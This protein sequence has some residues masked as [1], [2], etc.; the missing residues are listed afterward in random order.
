MRRRFALFLSAML[1]IFSGVANANE[2]IREAAEAF[3]SYGF[4][5]G[6]RLAPDGQRASF[7]TQHGSDVPVATVID[8]GGGGAQVVLASDAKKG[9]DIQWCGWKNDTRLLCGFYGL[10]RI[11]HRLIPHTRLVAVSADGSNTQVLAQRQQSEEF[12]NNQDEIVDWLPKD[13]SSILLQ[14]RKGGGTGVSSADIYK[15]KLT[16]V[17]RPRDGV[18]DWMSN[19][20]GE[21][22]IRQHVSETGAETWRYRPSEEEPWK[23]LHKMKPGGEG[24]EFLPLGFGEDPTKLLVL[25]AQEGRDALWS[26]DLQNELE[27]EVVYAHPKADITG[28][29]RLGRNRR[30]V[31]ATYSTDIPRAKYFDPRVDE[32]MSKVS[33]KISDGVIHIVDESWDRRFYLVFVE[34]D[35]NARTYY[36]F[37]SRSGSL[38]KIV[39]AF[40]KLKGRTLGEVKIIEY[41]SDDGVLV[42]GYLTLPAGGHSG[43]VPTIL[44]PHGGP[45]ARDDWGFDFL[46]QFLASQGYAVLQS[47]Y[48]GSSGYGKAWEGEGAYKG[49][50]RATTDLEYGLRYLVSEGIADADRICSVGWSYGGYAALMSAIEYP[51]RHRCVV[52]IA[53]VADLNQ[54]ISDARKSAR[55]FVGNSSKLVRNMIGQDPAV[56][57]QG[58]PL[59]RADELNVPVL[60]FHGDY[61]I[62]VPIA[63][64][65][66]MNKAL[67]KKD[68][69]YIEYE[70]DDHS[71]RKEKH[72]IDLLS[73]L[74]EFL[75]TNL[76]P[77]E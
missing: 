65:K 52:S 22:L 63:H 7:L 11:R 77:R 41:P 62:N 54:L 9:I 26:I 12:S 60:L 64:S 5:R 4:V 33:K 72:R 17:E 70:D 75:K 20:R 10:A 43:P 49:W 46:A 40:P 27:R 37:D 15:N 55:I 59:K 53:G 69:K 38:D 14:V 48:R 58:S 45:S 29:V 50:K 42:P 24:G 19:G 34:S 73:R 21:V 23:V 57:K 39:D 1:F 61:D 56:I 28:V 68:V 13:R 66:R 2:S 71:L 31:A 25:S 35:V 36:R 74:G 18:W 30:L 32:I 3:G 76:A 8:L 6:M 16:S 67:K 51:D 44:M 47:N